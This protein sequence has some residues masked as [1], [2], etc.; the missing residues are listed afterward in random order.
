M[1]AKEKKVRNEIQK[2][3]TLRQIRKQNNIEKLKPL[4][5][6]YLESEEYKHVKLTHKYFLI[7]E[8]LGVS[9]QSIISYMRQIREE[10]EQTIKQ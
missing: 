2:Y 10:E 5:K 1:Q 7:A 4:I 6:K 3:N 9:Y 8:E